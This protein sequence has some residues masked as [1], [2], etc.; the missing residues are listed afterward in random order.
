M[1]RPLSDLLPPCLLPEDTLPTMMNTYPSVT[2]SP[3]RPF[4]CKLPGFYY[5]NRK[6]T[7]ARAFARLCISFTEPKKTEKKKKGLPWSHLWP[8][9]HLPPDSVFLSSKCRLKQL[10]SPWQHLFLSH[11]FTSDHFHPTLLCFSWTTTPIH[12]LPVTA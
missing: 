12:W 5:S 9:P 7:N 3:N 8:T 1:C 10:Y 6:A 11:W 2:R 4:F